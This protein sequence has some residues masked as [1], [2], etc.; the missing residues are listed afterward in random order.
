MDLRS[1][2]ISYECLTEYLYCAFAQTRN[3]KSLSKYTWI[4]KEQCVSL[5]DIEL[6]RDMW[7]LLEIPVQ[8]HGTIRIDSFRRMILSCPKMHHMI[9]SSNDHTWIKKMQSNIV[10]CVLTP[11]EF[12]T[13]HGVR[14]LVS[15]TLYIIENNQHQ[16]RKQQVLQDLQTHDLVCLMISCWC[17]SFDAK[18]CGEAFE[19][20]M[21]ALNSFYEA[22]DDEDVEF[23][24]RA[25]RNE[26]SAPCSKRIFPR[27]RRSRERE[28]LNEDVALETLSFCYRHGALRKER[29]TKQEE[30]HQAFLALLSAGIVS[31][32][33]IVSF[34]SSV[35]ADDELDTKILSKSMIVQSLISPHEAEKLFSVLRDENKNKKRFTEATLCTVA[36][37]LDWDVMSSSTFFSSMTPRCVAQSVYR[38]FDLNAHVNMIDVSKHLNS[39]RSICARMYAY[40]DVNVN[41]EDS[42]LKYLSEQHKKCCSCWNERLVRHAVLTKDRTLL[43]EIRLSLS[44]FVESI[45]CHVLPDKSHVRLRDKTGKHVLNVDLGK[46]VDWD[47]YF[48]GYDDV[49]DGWTFVQRSNK[50]CVVQ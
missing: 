9:R 21:C 15:N 25:C 4:P 2:G 29:T 14:S 37:L 16:H 32:N 43:R 5:E 24:R 47:T 38:G 33:T 42:M 20:M 22:D 10:R 27:K 28:F 11:T 48:D 45:E 13:M 6:I 8:T 40:Y 23:V 41:A 18:S 12:N 7:N 26:Y 34:W 1:S 30:A 35:V 44:W 36:S 3:H 50:S 39:I 17:G 19:A 31:N 49:I 46:R